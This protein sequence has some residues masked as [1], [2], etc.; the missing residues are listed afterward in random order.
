MEDGQTEP[1][2]VTRA[3]LDALEQG[4][5]AHAKYL[6]AYVIR[7]VQGVHYGWHL[8]ASERVQ[9][10]K[11][12]RATIAAPLTEMEAADM[13]RWFV[14]RDARRFPALGQMGFTPR[15]AGASGTNKRW[16]RWSSGLRTTHT[17]GFQATTIPEQTYCQRSR[18]Q[19]ASRTTERSSAATRRLY[20]TF[21]S[22]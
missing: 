1:L 10:R 13:R 3:T 20:A 19:R 9:F 11:L 16:V 22:G 21:S 18:R 15:S 4:R 2:E 8:I 17:S 5:A 14:S 12:S 7:A 6:P